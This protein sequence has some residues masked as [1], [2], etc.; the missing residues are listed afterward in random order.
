V[1]LPNVAVII[2]A[3][4]AGRTLE[5]ALQS[6]ARQTYQPAEVVIVDD[7]SEPPLTLPP[8][9]SRAQLLR[10]D[11]TQGPGAARNL[12]L[13]RVSS[14]LVAVQDADDVS[15]PRRLESLAEGLTA[16]PD[17]VALG[18]QAVMFQPGKRVHPHPLRPTDRTVVHAAFA[19]GKMRLIHPSVM[20][21]RHVAEAVGGYP[22]GVYRGEDFIF[23]RRMAETG[24][25]E[26]LS[27]ALYGYRSPRFTPVRRYLEDAMGKREPGDAMRYAN[28]RELTRYPLHLARRAGA[29][30]HAASLVPSLSEWRA[31]LSDLGVRVR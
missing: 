21:R 11:V 27:G 6:I 12:A 4:D 14:P 31:Y 26:N 1:G 16:S 23:L 19:G 17:L 3:K 9:L 25:I 22:V 8:V 18:T 2:A 7:G 5:P 15:H 24:A 10:T 30:R 13:S 28:V 20:F 29:A